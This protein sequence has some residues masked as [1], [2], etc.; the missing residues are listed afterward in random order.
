MDLLMGR[1]KEGHPFHARLLDAGVN[2]SHLAELVAE[3]CVPDIIGID[4]YLT[5]DRVL[6]HRVELY[7]HE[8]VGGNGRA[9]YVDIAA[10]RSDIPE[11]N[12][13][14]LSRLAEVWERYQRPI[15]ITERHAGCSREEQ[16]RWLMEGWHISNTARH[17]GIDIRA[18]TCWS[19]FG[20]ED[21][22]SMMTR[23]EQHYECGAFDARYEPPQ[24]TILAKAVQSLAEHGQ[25]DHPVLDRPGWWHDHD[26]T[27]HEAR[28]LVLDGFSRISSA[29]EEYSNPRRLRIVAS[30]GKADPALLFERHK[31][32]AV[33]RF[34]SRKQAVALSPK[35]QPS[36]LI[37]IFADGETLALDLPPQA[38]WKDYLDTFLDL[39]VDYRRGQL[40]CLAPSR[41]ILCN[42][43]VGPVLEQETAQ[44]RI[45]RVA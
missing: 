9:T 32:W 5:S 7:P 22:N 24:P 17:A 30:P 14:L 34:E 45:T 23:R 29:I 43:L 10:V 40:R 42:A 25:F 18:V 3:P 28:P 39:I 13:G 8:Q 6:D 38:N 35:E 1:V 12:T 26:M 16:L 21:W 36:R 20:A 44:Q 4:Y 15:A 37:S 11:K 41:S 19:L 2:L 31:A 27:P 33:V